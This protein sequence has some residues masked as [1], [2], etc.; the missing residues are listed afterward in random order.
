[1]AALNP[2]TCE[3]LEHGKKEFVLGEAI[4]SIIYRHSQVVISGDQGSIIRYA[5][6][7]AQVL[8]PSP[9]EN[10]KIT[11]IKTDDPIIATQMDDK[12]DEG[13][14]G[15]SDGSIKYI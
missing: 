8:P 12:N 1:M 15:A 7:T 11:R 10:E 13:I 5:D 14:I 2:K 4:S 6:K 3:W 9:N